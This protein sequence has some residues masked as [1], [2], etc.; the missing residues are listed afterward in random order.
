MPYI[1]WRNN[2][3]KA[4]VLL[5]IK[6]LCLTGQQNTCRFS[7]K[8]STGVVEFKWNFS[9]SRGYTQR[10][11]ETSKFIKMSSTCLQLLH[12]DGRTEKNKGT[13]R[14]I[15]VAFSPKLTQTVNVW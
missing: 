14:H 15:S 11:S 13:K 8:V 5:H 3:F 12:A 9:E 7:S 1:F 2:I 4:F 6:K 10:T